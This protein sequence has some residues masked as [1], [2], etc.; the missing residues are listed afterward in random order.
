MDARKKSPG[1]KNPR[2]I[3]AQKN[4][5][6]NCPLRKSLIDIKHLCTVVNNKLINIKEWFTANK[7]SLNV[8]KTKHSFFSKPSKKDDIPLR[9][10]NLVIN[11]YLIQRQK[12]IKLLRVFLDQ[13]L[14]WK[15][16]VKLTE[17][18]IAK[19]HRYIIYN[20]RPYLDKRRLLCLYYSCIHFY[21]NYANTTWCSTVVHLKKFQSKQ[22]HVVRMI[23]YKN[24]FAHTGEH[25]KENNIL[26]I[27][28]LNIS[29]NFLFL[30]RVKAPI[31][32]FS[33]FLRPSHY[34]PTSFSQN[35]YIVPSFKLTKSK[36]KITVRAPKLW[37][38]I[39]NIEENFIENPAFFKA[40][41]KTMLVLLENAI[42]Y[43]SCI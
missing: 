31:V 42:V 18:K 26:N 11:N 14:T 7:L 19:K 29:N 37:N 38:V 15:E 6:I 22:K 17:N 2:K 20:A 34:Y 32:F 4:A 41:I 16:Q 35:N 21:L 30:H 3:V 27:C 28:Q 40:T 39:L 1:E 36:Y 5:P 13:H 12:S 23:F 33:K 43:F 8:E 24:K 9:L 25:F 10:P